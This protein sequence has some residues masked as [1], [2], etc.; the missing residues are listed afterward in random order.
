MYI[1]KKDI[2]TAGA[3]FRDFNHLLQLNHNN[4]NSVKLLG[5]SW[6]SY[7]MSPDEKALTYIFR[8]E[9]QE[10]LVVQEGVVETGQWEILPL[11]NSLLINNGK[12]GVLLNVMF[13]G[14]TA[15]VL[16]KENM[17]E[18]LILLKRSKENLHEK[19][20]PKLTLS[21]I[22]DYNRTQKQFDNI[23]LDA[24]DPALEFEDIAE[25][26]EYRLFPYVAT[27]GS[28]VLLLTVLI[29]LIRQF[30]WVAD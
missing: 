19:S 4:I 11:S 22:D 27:L 29:I 20:F 18:Y 2:E 3:S 17:E 25:F 28:I 30:W 5:F 13:F 15:L 8:E 7:A 16:K 24:T 21:L 14:N 1:Q 23:S 6:V 12:Q 10:L 26:H 9:N